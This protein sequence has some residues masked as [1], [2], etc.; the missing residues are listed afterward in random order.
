MSDFIGLDQEKAVL[1]R[2]RSELRKDVLTAPAPRDFDANLEPTGGGYGLDF[3]GLDGDLPTTWVEGTHQQLCPVLEAGRW[4]DFES[5]EAVDDT[6]AISP[7]TDAQL[8]DGVDASGGI[9]TRGTGFM[10]VEVFDVPGATQ[11]VSGMGR[12]GQLAHGSSVQVQVTVPAKRGKRQLNLYAGILAAVLA[13]SKVK[14][15]DFGLLRFDSQPPQLVAIQE[16]GPAWL[17]GVWEASATR[18]YRAPT[19]RG[20]P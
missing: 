19:S 17:T 7:F 15:T 5:A 11:L 12:R 8:R 1:A 18:S 20:T 10:V 6:A 16:V 14:A 9:L 4:V 13:D 3:T 2:L